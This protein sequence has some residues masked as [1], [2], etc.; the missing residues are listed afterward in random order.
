MKMPFFWSRT[1]LVVSSDFFSEKHKCTGS[2]IDTQ[3]FLETLFKFYQQS[4]DITT[5]VDIYIQWKLQTDVR[6]FFSAVR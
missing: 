5:F 3:M 6:A 2:T 1:S 4:Q